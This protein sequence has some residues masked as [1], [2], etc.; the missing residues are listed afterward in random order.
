MSYETIRILVFIGG[1]V[2]LVTSF[3]DG[4]VQRTIMNVTKTVG[5]WKKHHR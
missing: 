2:L 1:L 5:Q 3:R 4:N